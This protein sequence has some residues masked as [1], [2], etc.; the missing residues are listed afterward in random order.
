[1][2]PFLYFL[3]CLLAFSE[4]TRIMKESIL[5]QTFLLCCL[6]VPMAASQNNDSV[7]MIPCDSTQGSTNGPPLP[8]LPDQFETR[9]EANIVQVKCA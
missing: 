2:C 4:K 3:L 1:M 8:E 6:F 7:R 9:I 5:K